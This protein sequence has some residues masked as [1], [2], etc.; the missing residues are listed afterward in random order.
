MRARVLA[1]SLFTSAVIVLAATAAPASASSG[2][3]ATVRNMGNFSYGGG[4]NSNN[5]YF[6]VD[7]T[8]LSTDGGYHWAL[9]GAPTIYV[10]I[11]TGPQLTVHSSS[12]G[13]TVAVAFVTPSVNTRVVTFVVQ[14]TM[15]PQPYQG[16]TMMF[17]GSVPA[18]YTCG[19][20]WS[21]GSEAGHNY[22][23]CSTHYSVGAVTYKNI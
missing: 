23:T 14:T 11:N 12:G 13:V 1:Y 22:S 9:F 8:F 5:G 3:T 7:T 21:R 10:P 15:S 6:E 4:A 18:G 19:F 17:K 16:A 2:V 20:V